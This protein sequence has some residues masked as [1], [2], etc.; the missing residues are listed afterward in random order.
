MTRKYRRAS[1]YP[2]LPVSFDQPKPDVS[3]PTDPRILAAIERYLAAVAVAKTADAD[4][5]APAGEQEE[6][7]RAS[8]AAR[9]EI[10]RAMHHVG[11][12]GVKHRGVIYSN[13]VVRAGPPYET[14]KAT[15]D[16]EEGDS[17]PFIKPDSS[18]P[19]LQ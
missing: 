18:H 16:P 19:R 10:V 12:N 4:P 14:L 8:N 6:A 9:V 13:G 7:Q 2:W 5:D 15:P 11:G 17:R 3:R 1:R